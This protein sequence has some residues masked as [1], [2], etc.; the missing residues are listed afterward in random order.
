MGSIYLLRINGFDVFNG[1]RPVV[2]IFGPMAMD[3]DVSGGRLQ[4]GDLLTE[5]V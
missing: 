1:A 4:A 3:T 5:F 2:V